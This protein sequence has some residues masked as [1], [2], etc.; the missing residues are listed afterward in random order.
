MTKHKNGESLEPR[1][2]L[3]GEP[4]LIADIGTRPADGLIGMFEYGVPPSI[5][6]VG[7]AAYFSGSASSEQDAE[8]WMSDGTEAGTVLVKDIRPGPEGSNPKYLEPSGGHVFFDADLADEQ[9][10]NAS[11]TYLW[12]SDGTDAGTI[13]LLKESYYWSRPVQFQ[14]ETY[15][16]ANSADQNGLWKSNGTTAG[17]ELVRT[18]A[19]LNGPKPDAGKMLVLEERLLFVTNSS[20]HPRGRSGLWTSD[21]TTAGTTQLM[22]VSSPLNGSIQFDQLTLFEGAAYFIATERGTVDNVETFSNGQFWR[23]DGT[24]EGTT[25]VMEFE[26]DIPHNL[27]VLHDQLLLFRN[28][29]I[30]QSDGTAVGTTLVADLGDA[31][32]D[33]FEQQGRVGPYLYFSSRE[34]PATLWR[35][36]GTADGTHVVWEIPAANNSARIDSLSSVSDTLLI[37]TNRDATFGRQLWAIAA[38]DQ[39]PQLLKEFTHFGSFSASTQQVDGDTYFAANDGQ[40]GTELWKTDGTVEGTSLVT[41]LNPGLSRIESSSVREFVP[42]RDHVL[43]EASGN[44]PQQLWST[45]GDTAEQLLPEAELRIAE[46]A[47]LGDQVVLAASDQVTGYELWTANESLDSIQMLA[48]IQPGFASSWPRGF[49]RHVTSGDGEFLYFSADVGDGRHEL[50]RTDGTAD[51]TNAVASRPS[52]MGPVG[53]HDLTSYGDQLVF[54]AYSGNSGSELWTSDGTD[55]GTKLL[56]DIRPGTGGSDPASFFVTDDAIYFTAEDSAGRELW[57]TDGTEVGTHR[58][59]DIFSGSSSSEP[60]DF[61]EYHGRVYFVATGATGRGI[62]STDGTEGG[63]RAL[64][65]Q[66]RMNDPSDLFVYDDILYFAA[67]P[68]NA[69]GSLAIGRELWRSDGTVEGT[70]MVKDIYSASGSSSPSEFTVFDGALYFAAT[71]ANDSATLPGGFPLNRELWKTDGTAEGTVLVADINP[72]DPG[73][74]PRHLTAIGD[75]LYFTADNGATGNEPWVLRIDR[76]PGDATGDGTVSFDDFLI[77]SANFGF[78]TDRA[79]AGGDFNGDG[80]TSFEDFL[81]LSNNFGV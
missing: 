48:D 1:L 5:A 66:R 56:K 36:N 80:E 79:F 49:T 35:T 50:W 81:I 29:E 33:L 40:T 68:E 20:E 60:A 38:P 57:R 21:G 54:A 72:G 23:T 42:F 77:V 9:V 8:L 22:D 53:P 7:D 63:T 2:A 64:P 39:E 43:F 32:H 69:V 67:G 51:G 24:P 6:R 65:T 34:S 55:A 26:N 19:N 61:V 78:A 62:W 28:G 58:V 15:F 4:T 45:D 10:E 11:T 52:S 74:H 44:R 14:G 12:A 17:T 46:F 27:S 59:A 47:V 73:S 37:Q 70:W 41:D 18:T 76:L 75:S 71:S 16:L 25:L 3:S 31:R 30:W 13:P